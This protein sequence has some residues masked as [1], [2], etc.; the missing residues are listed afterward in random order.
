MY[1]VHVPC[2]YI[3]TFVTANPTHPTPSPS[4][5]PAGG[6]LSFQFSVSDSSLQRLQRDWHALLVDQCDVDRLGQ[7]IA[8]LKSDPDTLSLPDTDK[9]AGG[10][11]PRG[12]PS[13]GK[14]LSNS[15]Y[16]TCV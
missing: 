5:S 9:P 14:I 2:W 10:S 15:S 12:S 6:A 1:A 11:P 4:F 8:L 13:Q 16:D 3:R 7:A